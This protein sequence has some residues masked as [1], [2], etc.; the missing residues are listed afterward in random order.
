MMRQLV[1]SGRHT[2]KGY[3]AGNFGRWCDGSVVVGHFGDNA[4]PAIA[5]LDRLWKESDGDRLY[6]LNRVGFVEGY[7]FQV[8]QSRF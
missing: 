3:G 2:R 1:R 5:G 4:F 7:A 6:R 8:W